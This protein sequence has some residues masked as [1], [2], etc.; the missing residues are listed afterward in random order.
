MS[1]KDLE[2]LEKIEELKKEMLLNSGMPGKRANLEIIKKFSDF[3]KSKELNQEVYL[4]LIEFWSITANGD[5]P[6]TILCL[7]GLLGLSHYYLDNNYIEEIKIILIEAM[8]DSRWRVREVI[9]ETLK[10]IAMNDYN[11]LITFIDNIKDPTMLEY[12]AIITTL[13]HPEILLN[14]I[15]KEY[16]ISKLV[17]V[18]NAFLIFENTEDIKNEE[19]KALVKGLNFAP[20]VI[21]SKIPDKGFD[22]FEEYIGKSKNLNRIIKENLKKNRLTKLN[23]KKCTDL[24]NSIKI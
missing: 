17:E 14:N 11:D 3:I 9:Q 2:T 12:R 13:A 4:K 21:V 20:S 10:I 6:N 15:Q 22:I 16:A 24:I 23:E 19:F 5:D 7:A 18:F 8:N 1:K